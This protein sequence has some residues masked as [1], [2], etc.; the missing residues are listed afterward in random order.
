M[1]ANTQVWMFVCM[2]VWGARVN[3]RHTRHHRSSRVCEW[4]LYV[5][6]RVLTAVVHSHNSGQAKHRY[7]HTHQWSINTTVF[8]AKV[9]GRD[10][11][12]CMHMHVYMHVST[13]AQ[14]HFK[15]IPTVRDWVRHVRVCALLLFANPST[16][17]VCTC[18][19]VCPHACIYNPAMLCM[20]NKHLMLDQTAGIYTRTYTRSHTFNTFTQAQYSVNSHEKHAHSLK[21]CKPVKNAGWQGR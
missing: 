14:P 13:A 7:S 1:H 15:G 18:T 5:C 9:K 4:S 19:S 10:Q 17:S 3:Q 12:A 11:H 21:R 8:S 16:V 6:A 20:C 2:I